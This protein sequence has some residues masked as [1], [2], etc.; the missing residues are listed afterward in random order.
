MRCMLGRV[1]PRLRQHGPALLLLSLLPRSATMPMAAQASLVI[2]VGQHRGNAF[3]DLKRSLA[4]GGPALFG[5]T[6]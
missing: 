5:Q 2:G 3:G 1:H 6:V 4:H